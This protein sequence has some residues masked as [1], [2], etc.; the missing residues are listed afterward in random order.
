MQ[1]VQ[2]KY[3]KELQDFQVLG[4]K[5]ELIAQQKIT[6]ENSINIKNRSIKELERME[7]D[8]SIV[9]RQIGGILIKKNKDIVIENLKDEVLTQEMRSKT[10][11]KSE[12]SLK[13][14]FEGMRLRLQKRISQ[15]NQ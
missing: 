1:N 9:Y 12:I 6:I 11:E 10:L 2:N 3:D 13:K 15:Q 14:T 5:L 4:Q 8:D 7:E